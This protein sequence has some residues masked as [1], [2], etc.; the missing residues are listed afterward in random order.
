MIPSQFFH[1]IGLSRIALTWLE[2]G[3]CLLTEDFVYPSPSSLAL[4]VGRDEGRRA[5]IFVSEHDLQRLM[6]K[7][8]VKQEAAQPPGAVAEAKIEPEF[9]RWREQHPNGYIPTEGEDIEHMKKFGVSRDTVRELRKG[10][11][12]A[13]PRGQKK[14]DKPPNIRG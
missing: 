8:E 3:E 9:R 4:G 1:S 14:S 10:Y 6:A 11:P 5:T 2:Q 12:K 7:Q 13:K